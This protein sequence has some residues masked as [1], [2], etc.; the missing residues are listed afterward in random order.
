MPRPLVVRGERYDPVTQVGSIVIRGA[1]DQDECEFLS[2]M[3]HFVPHDLFTT[4]L[5]LFGH[6]WM[7]EDDYEDSQATSESRMLAWAD[8]LYD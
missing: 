2:G 7:T 1:L 3:E 4:M 8:G 5:D 6:E